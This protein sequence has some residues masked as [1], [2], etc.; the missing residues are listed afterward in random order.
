MK[1]G[2]SRMTEKNVGYSTAFQ[3]AEYAERYAKSS[4]RRNKRIARMF[5]NWLAQQGF[6]EGTILDVGC[7]SGDIAIAI[8]STFPRARIAGMDLS[9]PMLKFSQSGAEKAGVADRVSFRKG[10]AKSMPFEDKSFDVVISLNTFHLID[11]PVGMLNE[12]ERVLKPN[13]LLLVTDIR[14]SWMRLFYL[15]LKDALTVEQAKEIA[16]KSKL[17]SHEL[18]QGSVWLAFVVGRH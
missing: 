14:R 10:D 5:T 1:R 7:G 4:A 12:V 13:G 17:R 18:Q 3:D 16:S 2:I 9:E 6:E 11:D 15:P 8:A